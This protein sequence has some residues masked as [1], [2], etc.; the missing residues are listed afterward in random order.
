MTKQKIF[1]SSVQAE[2]AVERKRLAEYIRQDALFSR[3]FEPFLF[4]E[5]PAQDVSAQ[6]AYLEQAAKSEVYLLLVGEQYGY[7]DAEG[8]SPTER[9]YDT[10][11]AH[12]AYRI[13]FIKSASTRDGKE[14]VFRHKI[15]RDVIRNVFGS[16]EELQSGVYASL[17]EYMT[18]HHILRQGPFDASV[19]PDA[20]IEDLDKE[21]IRRFVSLA[22][23]KRQ[24]PLQYSEEDIPHILDS[25]HL[26]TDN[27]QLKNAALLLFA[28]DVQKWFVSATVKCAQFY[29]TK[30]QKPIAS[31]QIYGGSVFEQVDMAVSFVMTRIDQRVGER[32]R[33]AEVDVTPELPTQAVTEA[34]VN[35]VVH[36]D[37]TS[38]GSVQVMLFKDRLEVWNPGRLP[39]GMTIEKL[40]GKHNS[41][42]VN[43]VLANPVYLTGYI[44]Q[45]GTGTTDIIEQCE[46]HGLRRP[47]FIQ[48][49][50]FMTILW[51]PEKEDAGNV[52]GNVAGSA[53]DHV[54]DHVAD[55]VTDH[56]KRLI[57][58]IR[59]D[60]KTRDEIMSCLGLKNRGNL[61]DGY[62]KPAVSAG[63]VAM[64]YPASPRRTDQAYYLTEKGLEMLKLIINQVGSPS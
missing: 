58:A 59:G 20:C 46:S 56:V 57:L 51:R 43:P 3:Y 8:V 44:E 6:T 2:F 39:Q 47:Q 45:M 15:D 38:T 28:K 42:P 5:L 48:D 24:F 31:L 23:E 16:Y 18:T 62:I 55:H 61:R 26:I 17:V 25:L 1:I 34:I 10:A 9:E 12:H 19:H 22:R 40:N 50:D 33:S 32:T 37:Y 53:T 11:T 60:T 27:H 35:A 63:Y 41:Q 30:M 13:A 52:T 54:T 7:Q 49:D 29:G 36:R 21:K 4:E 14:D 64:L